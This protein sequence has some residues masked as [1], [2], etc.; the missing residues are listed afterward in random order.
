MCTS[1]PFLWAST[2]SSAMGK[3]A[4]ELFQQYLSSHA[5]SIAHLG[6][7]ATSLMGY[8]ADD[9]A[10]IG[11]KPRQSS[12]A[13]QRG[14]RSRS[15]REYRVSARR[16]ASSREADQRRT[17]EP[18]QQGRV[19]RLPRPPHPRQVHQSKEG[20]KTFSGGLWQERG[21]KPHM[22]GICAHFILTACKVGTVIPLYM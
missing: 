20:L 4:L 18:F 15:S 8:A 6:V 19:R 1:P 10:S 11:R 5:A 14:T 22:Y 3:N 17:P 16:E 9:M 2:L 21:K 12:E 13:R 7:Q